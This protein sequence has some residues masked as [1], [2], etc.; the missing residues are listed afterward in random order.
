MFLAGIPWLVLCAWLYLRFGPGRF[1]DRLFF[2]GV[3]GL[4][5]CLGIALI[6]RHA[7]ATVA[8]THDSV[9]WPVLGCIY[10][11]GFV[12]AVLAVAAIVRMVVYRKKIVVPRR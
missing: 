10:T 4:V 8:G 5:L 6:T 11:L 1:K 7:Y 2:E 3:V 12:P 9:W